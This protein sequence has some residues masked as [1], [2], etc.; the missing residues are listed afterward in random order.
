[1]KFWKFWNE[2]QSGWKQNK[3]NH[4]ALIAESD[5]EIIGVIEM[6]GFSHVALFCVADRF[7]RKGVGKALFRQ[8]V[9]I[10]SQDDVTLSQIT[11]NASPNSVDAY[12]ALGF[13]PVDQERCVNGIR[14][15]PMMCNLMSEKTVA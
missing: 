14:F 8:A 2:K 10:C 9:E 11:V 4:F 15:V 13:K 12:G 3:E 7:Q 6:R 1:M 5:E